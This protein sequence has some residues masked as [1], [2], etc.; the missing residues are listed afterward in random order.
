M[1]MMCGAS[2]LRRAGCKVSSNINL[3]HFEN[4]RYGQYAS[5]SPFIVITCSGHDV[6]VYP[7]ASQVEPN[8]RGERV[9]KKTCSM[10]SQ[11]AIL[12]R[13]LN[14]QSTL[15]A[16]SLQVCNHLL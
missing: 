7:L 14:A 9:D 5:C 6:T 11:V 15:A 16:C 4:I 10:L 3:T 8:T 12:K 1:L 13:G 2:V